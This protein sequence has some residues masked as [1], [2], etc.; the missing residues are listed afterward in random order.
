MILHVTYKQ[1]PV[2]IHKYWEAYTAVLGVVVPSGF[3]AHDIFD[4]LL[5]HSAEVLEVIP[6]LRRFIVNGH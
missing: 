6:P 4:I 2:S 1:D 5:P 3:G